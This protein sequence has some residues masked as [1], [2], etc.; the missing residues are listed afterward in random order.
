MTREAG[1]GKVRI[2]HD[3]LGEMEVP[4][5][6]LYGAQTARAVANFPVSGWPLPAGFLVALARIKAAF[7]RANGERGLLPPEIARA[8]SAAAGEIAGGAHL[9]QFPVDVFQTGSGTSSNMNMNEVVAHLANLALG[10]DP[11]AHRPV[12]PND[13]VNLGQSSNDAVPAALRV[14][15]ASAW[16]DLV[17][18][19]AAAVAA[20][21]ERL[22]AEHGATVTL[23]RTHLM[24]AVPTTYGRVF[25]AWA[26]RVRAASVRGD[27]AAAHLLELPLGGTAVGSGIN[28]DP[29][30]VARAVELLA[31]DT[32]LALTVAV[33]PAAGIAAQEAPIAFADALAGCGRVLFAVANDIRLRSSGPFGG[34]GELLL[35][36][37]QPG[38]SIM[39]GKVNP[40]I[41]EA[42]AQVALEVE[43]LAAACRASAVLHQLDLS[44]ANPL[45]AWNLDT[46]ARL[47]ANACDLLVS[48][49]LDGLRVNV[50]RARRLA[51]S[52]PALATALAARIG[53]ERAAAVAKAAEAAGES[54]F[55]AAR[56]LGVLPEAELAEALNLERLA[57]IS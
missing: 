52:S 16:R 3:T 38:S 4:Q 27:E 42:V 8:I 50:E 28:A 35:P 36:V 2:E 57:G 20:A 51:A 25:A 49:C 45:L 1:R 19:A 29:A 12:H 14:A 7:A 41:P 54:V 55:D 24:D 37:V 56:R 23:G 30:A 26:E 32:G 40:V 18:T 39:P 53:Y 21:F 44:H 17:R 43:G 22:A 31:S 5:A 46:M 34:F 11:A 33:S 10:G 15:A 13:H 47:L 9:E 48:R 6:A